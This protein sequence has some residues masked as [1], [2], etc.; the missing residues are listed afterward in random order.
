[1]HR[2]E[3]FPLRWASQCELYVPLRCLPLLAD[4]GTGSRVKTSGEKPGSGATDTTTERDPQIAGVL[5]L[6]QDLTALAHSESAGDLFGHAFSTL[7]RTVPFDVGVAV[8]L[9]QHIDLYISARSNAGRQISQD[10]VERV[11]D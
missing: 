6:V 5:S 3:S 2:T 11:R 8:M 9:E 10:L 7:A 4:D 1:M